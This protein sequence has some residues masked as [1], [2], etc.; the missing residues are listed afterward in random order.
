MSWHY[1][2]DLDVRRCPSE[3]GDQ[4]FGKALYGELRS[5][6]GRMADVGSK[7]RPKA[8]DARGVDD[9][10]FIGGLQHRQK[11]AHA[12]IDAAPTDIECSFPVLTTIRDDRAAAANS[13]I[14]EKQMQPGGVV[15][16][17][18]LVPEADQLAL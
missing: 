18:R 9:V 2:R 13:G 7:A 8:V 16:F 12:Q 17:G 11:G 3:V 1:D 14:V 15:G 4:G 6:I 5:R 10:G